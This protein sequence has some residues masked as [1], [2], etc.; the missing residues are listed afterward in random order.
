VNTHAYIHTHI[1]STG[2]RAA[3]N[4][5]HS[6][7]QCTTCDRDA[8]HHTHAKRVQCSD[9]THTHASKGSVLCESVLPGV[10]GRNKGACGCIQV[11][12][13][14]CVCVGVLSDM[15]H[16]HIHTHTQGRLHP[17]I[18]RKWQHTIRACVGVCVGVSAWS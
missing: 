9:C 5:I 8:L 4:S 12:M 13:S 15:M 2:T 1:C 18:L 16:T 14:T 17:P 6:R 7:P 10:N 3:T 11:C